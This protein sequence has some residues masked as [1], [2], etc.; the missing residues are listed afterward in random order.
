[1]RESYAACFS[2]GRSLYGL[3]LFPLGV[4]GGN[5]LWALLCGLGGWNGERRVWM[6]I[7]VGWRSGGM[8]IWLMV[9]GYLIEGASGFVEVELNSLN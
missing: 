4:K 2:F 6:G 7:S 5:G 8:G 3:R 9:S 1:M